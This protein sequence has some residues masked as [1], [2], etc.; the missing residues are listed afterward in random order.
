M[1]APGSEE[2]QLEIKVGA[3]VLVALILLIA[4]ILILGDWS[5]ESQKKVE[6]FFENPGGLIG[7]SAVKVA[8]RKIGTIEEMTFV[9]QNGPKHPATHR[10]TLVRVRISINEDVI[11][12][13]KN[14]ARFYVTTKGML[15]DPFL[16]IDPGLSPTKMNVEKPIFGV[17]PPRFDLLLADAYE[18]IRGLNRLLVRN[19]DNLDQLLGTGARLMGAV[20]K[21]VDG[22]VQTA[23]VDRILDGVENLLGETRSLVKGTREKYVD[24]PKITRIL[25]NFESLSFKLNRDIDPLLK[26]VREALAAL[27]RLSGTIGPEEQQRIKQAIAKLDGIMTRTSK[28]MV[29]VD[30]II[31]RIRKGDGT[32]GQMLNDEEIYDDIKELIRDIKKHPWKIIWED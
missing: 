31:E 22:G 8:G 20:E 4:F 16:E 24:D 17:D 18:L 1:N 25:S 27:E 23:R 14:D 10:P 11:A 9:G 3:M 29:S 13:L 2:R 6:V 21:M 30:G 12:S 15:G 26:E 28:T 7:G 19:A 5:L 32:I